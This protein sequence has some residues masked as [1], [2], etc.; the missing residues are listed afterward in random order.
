MALLHSVSTLEHTVQ[1]LLIINSQGATVT[2]TIHSLLLKNK[3]MD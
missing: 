2:T 3:H 1:S